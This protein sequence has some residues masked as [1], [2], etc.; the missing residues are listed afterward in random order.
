MSFMEYIFK[1]S[2]EDLRAD[3]LELK[4]SGKERCRKSRPVTTT[5]CKFLKSSIMRMPRACE[6]LAVEDLIR[7]GQKALPWDG[8]ICSDRGAET[9]RQL[10]EAE[11]SAVELAEPK[12][13]E[14]ELAE[15]SGFCGGQRSKNRSWRR[16]LRRR[17]LQ[18]RALQWSRQSQSRSSRRA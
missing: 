10:Q 5:E 12:E 3:F 6:K 1:R 15:G 14:Q 17:A 2:A 18:W 9:P 11:G 13:Q 16:A 4:T 8:P 7:G